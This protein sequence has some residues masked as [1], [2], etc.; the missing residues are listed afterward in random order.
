MQYAVGSNS[1]SIP[2]LPHTVNCILLT[3]YCLLHTAYCKKGGENH[4][5]H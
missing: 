1:D 2:L 4:G 5:W 3:A